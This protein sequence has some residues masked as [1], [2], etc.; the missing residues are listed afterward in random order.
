MT[1]LKTKLDLILD[2]VVYAKRE[3]TLDVR[4]CTE[5]QKARVIAMAEARGLHAASDGKWILV[6]D[7]RPP[8]QP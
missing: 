8:D 7:L 2:A 3:V 6:R 1:P 4:D 5:E